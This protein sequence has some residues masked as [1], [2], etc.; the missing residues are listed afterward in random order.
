MKYSRIINNKLQRFELIM[1]YV[2]INEI[3]PNPYQPRAVFKQEELWELAKSIREFGIIEPLIVRINE[4]RRYE[5][6]AGERR[7]RA[8]KLAGLEQVPIILRQYDD[9]RSAQIAL[10]ENLQRS[11]LNAVEEAKAYRQLLDKFGMT[12]EI[13]A[14]KVGKS[15]SH[16]ANFLRL[17]HL[18]EPVLAMV[19]DGS[20]S[21]GQAKP[22]LALDGEL[23]LKAAEL[24]EEKNLS[25]R[26]AENLVKQLLRDADALERIEAAGKQLPQDVYEADAVQRLKQVL[27][28]NVN[29]KRGRH[30]SR[31]EI[32]FYSDED[33]Q[34]L[35]EAISGAG[36]KGSGPAGGGPK[37]S[38]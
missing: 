14:Q 6:I 25:A 18:T 13:V 10:I 22:L 5:L 35:I 15:R 11:D 27:G 38:I 20:L 33:L 8:A 12:Q 3:L 19:G 17:L 9:R 34:R 31:L 29:I 16:I 23:Q 30:K 24:I 37:F 1:D 2:E 28:T 36:D 32:E 26:R 7:L 4:D 21:M